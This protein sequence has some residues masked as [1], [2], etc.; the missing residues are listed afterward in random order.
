MSPLPADLPSKPERAHIGENATET[1]E[2]ENHPYKGPKSTKKR[3]PTRAIHGWLP[4]RDASCV[5][6]LWGSGNSGNSENSGKF[7]TW[8][9]DVP[10]TDAES[11]HE[12]FALL[13][14][15][16]ATRLGF[17]R[18]CLSFRRFSR[19]RPV[20][21][22][23]IGGSST[24]FSALAEPLGLDQHRKDFSERQEEAMEIIRPITDFD[25]DDPGHCY[26]DK[27]SGEYEHCNGACPLNTSKDRGVLRCP[28]EEWEVCNDLLKWIEDEPFLSSYFRDLTGARSQNIPICFIGHCFIHKYR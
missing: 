10:I 12:I 3:K 28:F 16:Y 27:S 17:L 7:I 5:F 19:L 4:K 23:F 22:R 26:R 25:S 13:A 9:M 20:T 21:F 1:T 6:L 8:A 15:Q 11:E 2:Y 14:K 24:R 18:R